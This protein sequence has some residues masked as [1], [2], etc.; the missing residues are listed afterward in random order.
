MRQPGDLLRILSFPIKRGVTQVYYSEFFP[1]KDKQKAPIFGVMF[2]PAPDPARFA[3]R[4]SSAKERHP[5][6]SLNCPRLGRRAI[7]G[8]QNLTEAP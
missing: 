4:W 7:Y 5:W 8:T 1:K 2:C 6:I 3:Y